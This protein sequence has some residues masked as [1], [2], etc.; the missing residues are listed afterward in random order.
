MGVTN[1]PSLPPL[2]FERE[3]VKIFDREEIVQQDIQITETL[4]K[5]A[6]PA[7]RVELKG[8]PGE[9]LEF[10]G[11]KVCAY[12]RDQKTSVNFRGKWSEYK[13]HLCNCKTLQSMRDAGRERRYLATQR[14]DGFFTVHDLTVSPPE[15]GIVKMDLCQNCKDILIQKRIYFAPFTLSDFFKKFNTYVPRTIRRVEEVRTIQTYTPDHADIAREAKIAAGYRCQGCQV[16]CGNH[17]ELLHMHHRNGD[18]SDNS[19]SNLAV[20]CVDCHSKQPMHSR[21]KRNPQFVDGINLV[22]NLRRDQGL[23]T[24]N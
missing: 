8:R 9:L 19:H 7:S 16:D 6:L 14:I 1:I 22:L 21:M 2:K 13:Y 18:P 12:I 5:D 3:V 10:Q 15:K 24:V 20:L 17:K 11:R 4:A 23:L